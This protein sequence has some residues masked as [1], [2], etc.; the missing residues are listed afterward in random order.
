L[1]LLQPPDAPVVQPVSGDVNFISQCFFLTWR[2]LH[3]SIVQQLDVFEM[4]LRQYS[5]TH[6]NFRLTHPAADPDADPRINH[7]RR[8]ILFTQ[9]TNSIVY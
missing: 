6:H 4:Y 3:L 8:N 2:S 7:M 1:A 9:V 5:Y